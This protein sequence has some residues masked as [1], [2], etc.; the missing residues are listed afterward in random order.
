MCVIIFISFIIKN[1]SAMLMGTS[2]WLSAL[3]A[4]AQ[5]YEVNSSFGKC[6]A[7]CRTLVH[8]KQRTMGK[9]GNHFAMPELCVGGTYTAQL[10]RRVVL[11]CGM[12]AMNSHSMAERPA[13]TFY[14]L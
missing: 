7:I 2:T 4:F 1:S 8:L 6:I 11:I 13:I 9:V 12:D 10:Y 3:G 5:F 14:K